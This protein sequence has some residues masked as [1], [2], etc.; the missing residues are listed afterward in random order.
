MVVA[1]GLDSYRKIHAPRHHHLG[2]LCAGSRQRQVPSVDDQA[3]LSSHDRAWTGA[4]GNGWA[5]VPT[6]GNLHAH[7]D[8]AARHLAGAL[9]HA[10][11]G[12]TTVLYSRHVD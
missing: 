6:V 2:P 9:S 8:W 11:L 12:F 7:C 1:H 4:A 5:A 3:S 10:H